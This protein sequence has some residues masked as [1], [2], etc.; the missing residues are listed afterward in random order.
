MPLSPHPYY[1]QENTQG[2][3]D[4]ELEALN[5]ELCCLLSGWQEDQRTPDLAQEMIQEIIQE[6]M[7]EIIKEHND[8][9]ARRRL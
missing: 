3:T 5:V 9:V 4:A 6:I 7:Q 8:D 1:T 2:Y